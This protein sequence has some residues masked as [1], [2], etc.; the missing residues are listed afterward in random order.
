VNVRRVAEQEAAP[1]AEARGG[2]M[3]DA[4]ENRC[5][6]LN[7]RLGPDSPRTEGLTSLKPMSFLS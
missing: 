5:K 1:V 7:S 3:V 2:A 6:A 4:V